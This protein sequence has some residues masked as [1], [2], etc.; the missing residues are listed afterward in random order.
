MERITVALQ[1][2]LPTQLCDCFSAVVLRLPVCVEYN[3][4]LWLIN[5]FS[6]QSFIDYPSDDLGTKMRYVLKIT[7]LSHN[8]SK[9]RWGALG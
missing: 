9:K 8:P 4:I 6:L 3:N 7:M 5:I 1:H 2:L